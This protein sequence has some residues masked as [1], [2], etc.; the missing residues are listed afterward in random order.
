MSCTYPPA[1]VSA[2]DRRYFEGVI[3]DTPV[4]RRTAEELRVTAWDFPRSEGQTL[5]RG[6]GFAIL[7]PPPDLPS[8]HHNSVYAL[9]MHRLRPGWL[10]TGT[11]GG[12][13]IDFLGAFERVFG[14]EP[15]IG[16]S[17][18]LLA[19]SRTRLG[20]R[21]TYAGDSSIYPN[22]SR[23]A[24]WYISG[25]PEQPVPGF[26]RNWSRENWINW[27]E[28]LEGDVGFQ[29][30]DPRETCYPAIRQEDYEHYQARVMEYL[31]EEFPDPSPE[32]DPPPPDPPPPDPEP[33]PEPDPPPGLSAVP[34]RV[35]ELVIESYRL[36]DA[37]V[38]GKRIR[39][40]LLEVLEGVPLSTGRE[41]DR[42]GGQ[43]LLRLGLEVAV[44]AKRKLLEGCPR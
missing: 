25:G 36:A 21:E 39:R 16:E 41:Y 27:L 2:R 34:Q 1:R 35:E 10:Q 9:V 23:I 3:V 13:S 42:E 14:R 22:R 32:P 26:A 7:D 29:S 44:R 12:H 43:D 5:L 4:G 18:N 28:R 24:S 8:R 15:T 20:D 11:V 38:W 31:A 6:D 40:T 19:H 17:I 30:A 37:P 33:E